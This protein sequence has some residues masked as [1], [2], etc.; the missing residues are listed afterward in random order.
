MKV[1]NPVSLDTTARA[2]YFS[3]FAFLNSEGAIFTLC[4]IPW[5]VFNQ[6]IE[7]KIKELQ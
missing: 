1:V 7:E 4:E 5:H 3:V 6:R 2:R